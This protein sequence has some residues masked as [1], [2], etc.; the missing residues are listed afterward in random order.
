MVRALENES[1]RLVDS[2]YKPF[3]DGDLQLI[4][5]TK[6]MNELHQVFFSEDLDGSESVG[7]TRN[8][9]SMKTK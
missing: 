5:N 2:Q 4:V 8:C 1:N 6:R 7:Q 3:V 9:K